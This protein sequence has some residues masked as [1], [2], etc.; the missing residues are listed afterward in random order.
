MRAPSRAHASAIVRT[1][2]G[3]T[4]EPSNFTERTMLKILSTFDW[5]TRV[6]DVYHMAELCKMSSADANAYYAKHLYAELG[7][8]HGTRSVY[9]A[10]VQGY[11]RGMCRVRDNRIMRDLVEYCYVQ[12]DVLFST[13]KVST[14]RSTEEFFA[15]GRGCELADLPSGFYW[16]GTDKPF[17]LSGE[18]TPFKGSTATLA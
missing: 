18:T 15:S 14:H 1:L 5:E 6:G 16:K 11:V 3:Y 9:P 10:Y 4:V 8:K 7:R 2:K 12:N 17:F 13:H